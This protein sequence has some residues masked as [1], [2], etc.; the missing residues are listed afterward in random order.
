MN[1]ISVAIL[2]AIGYIT[3]YNSQDWRMVFV[4]IISIIV[5]DK[6]WR[7]LVGWIKRTA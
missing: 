2:Y 1:S 6:I 5:F 4:G 7:T 3:G